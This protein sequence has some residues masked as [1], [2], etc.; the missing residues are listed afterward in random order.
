MNDPMKKILSESLFFVVCHN[1]FPAQ[2]FFSHKRII[3]VTV[4]TELLLNE[5]CYF[6]IFL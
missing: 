4:L 5:S 3:G 1:D 6:L 2:S